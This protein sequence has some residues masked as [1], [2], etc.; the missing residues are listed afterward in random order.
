MTHALLDILTKQYADGSPIGSNG[1]TNDTQL[2]S[3][4]SHLERLLN[5]RQ[6]GLTHLPDYGLPDISAI[7]QE[8]PDSA[9]VLTGAIKACIEKYEPRLKNVVVQPQT[10]NSPHSVLNLLITGQI[11][12]NN[13]VHY[14]SMFQGDGHAEVEMKKN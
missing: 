8:L 5:T 9:S 12:G 3:V 13:T 4:R 11:V 2:K 6:G 7:Y 14:I 10:S 1:S